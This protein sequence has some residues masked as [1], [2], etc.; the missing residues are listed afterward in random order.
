MM[1]HQVVYSELPGY[2]IPYRKKSENGLCK[3]F[4]EK[5]A[6]ILGFY[7]TYHVDGNIYLKSQSILTIKEQISVFLKFFSNPNG[8]TTVDSMVNQQLLVFKRLS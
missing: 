6:G 1:L 5:R 3:V 4:L 8:S 7:N 2:I